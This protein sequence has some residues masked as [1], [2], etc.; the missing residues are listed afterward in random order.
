MDRT[1]SCLR[2]FICIATHPRGQ[3]VSRGGEA[4]PQCIGPGA[5]AARTRLDADSEGRD[6]G[7]HLWTAAEPDG[8]FE[9]AERAALTRYYLRVDQEERTFLLVPRDSVAPEAIDPIADKL[10]A[11][12]GKIDGVTSSGEPAVTLSLPACSERVC[13]LPES[14]RPFR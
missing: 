3:I 4:N 2:S 10:P 7:Y 12:R 5:R 14:V 1:C 11:L 8:N 6:G 9:A 13:R